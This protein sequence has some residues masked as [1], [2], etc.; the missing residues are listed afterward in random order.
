MKAYLDILKEIYEKCDKLRYNRTGIPDIGLGYGATFVHD[1][2]MGFPLITTKKM[3]LKN[4]ATGASEIINFFRGFLHTV[5]FGKIALENKALEESTEQANKAAKDLNKT[6]S[7]EMAAATT[8]RIANDKAIIASNNAV[9]ASNKA[10]AASE[11]GDLFDDLLATVPDDMVGPMGGKASDMP[12]LAGDILDAMDGDKTDDFAKEL[13]SDLFDEAGEEIAE[14]GLKKVLKEGTEEGLE[15][16]LKGA[17]KNTGLFKSS[18]KTSVKL[19]YV[20][21]TF[22]SNNNSNLIKLKALSTSLKLYLYV[23]SFDV[24]VDIYCVYIGACF[25]ISNKLNKALF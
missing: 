15:Q 12:D 9:I 24:L 3:G 7:T 1:M 20:F 22:S 17:V 10:R 23:T 4:I 18:N 8:A 25:S 11:E 16:G 19:V 21:N 14:Q 13:F 2:E 6:M 5:S